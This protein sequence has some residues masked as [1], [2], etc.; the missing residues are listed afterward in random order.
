MTHNYTIKTLDFERDDFTAY[1]SIMLASQL[2]GI[3]GKVLKNHD[4]NFSSILSSITDIEPEKIID[5]VKKVLVKTKHKKIYI[6]L[7]ST[8]WAGKNLYVL[9][10]LCYEIV[11]EEYSDFIMES[12]LG[13]LMEKKEEEPQLQTSTKKK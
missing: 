12:G 7:D 13:E 2:A 10:E 3:V 11:K 5:I 8:Y 6:D 9:F 1:E 4:G